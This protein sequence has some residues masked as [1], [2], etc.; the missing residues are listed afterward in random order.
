MIK[1]YWVNSNE[2][3]RFKGIPFI[4]LLN[5]KWIIETVYSTNKGGNGYMVE[6][7]DNYIY[8]ALGFEKLLGSEIMEHF[9]RRENGDSR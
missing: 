8:D 6:V 2:I 1:E 5:K 3:E 4:P 9:E 7:N